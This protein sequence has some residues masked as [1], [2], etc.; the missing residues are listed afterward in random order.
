VGETVTT[1]LVPYGLGVHQY[2]AIRG[3]ALRRERYGKSGGSTGRPRRGR[4]CQRGHTMTAENSVQRTDGY[5]ACRAC[6]TLSEHRSRRRRSLRTRVVAAHPDRG[7]SASRF[8]RA[9]KRYQ[10]ER[11]S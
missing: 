6:M 3:W 10:K 7:G 8:V 11:A 9:L 5:V 2:A 4:H 1:A